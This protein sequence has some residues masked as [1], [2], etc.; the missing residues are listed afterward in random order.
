MLK[1][2]KRKAVRLAMVAAM[3]FMLIGQPIVAS[4]QATPPIYAAECAISGGGNC[5][6]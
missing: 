6:G 5:G 4:L 1:A 3:T 2:L